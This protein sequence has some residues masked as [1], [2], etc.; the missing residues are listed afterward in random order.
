M[1]TFVYISLFCLQSRED[2]LD[3]SAQLSADSESLRPLSCSDPGADQYILT[4]L[5]K[6]DSESRRLFSAESLTLLWRKTHCQPRVRPPVTCIKIEIQKLNPQ[7]LTCL[8]LNLKKEGLYY[9]GKTWTRIPNHF[10]I[11]FTV[12]CQTQCIIGD[13]LV[14]CSLSSLIWLKLG[15]KVAPLAPNDTTEVWHILTRLIVWT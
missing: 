6:L 9:C 5:S 11:I 4:Q 1:F 10:S 14:L 3:P 12:A 7:H 8:L 2:Y 13:F 15:C